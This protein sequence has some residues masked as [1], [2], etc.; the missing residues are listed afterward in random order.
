MPP[1]VG[2]EGHQFDGTM[3][4]LQV[5][6][7]QGVTAFAGEKG[8]VGKDACQV[9]AAAKRLGGDAKGG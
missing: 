7:G 4:I 8:D 1:E 6:D 9:E 3:E 2:R 5:G